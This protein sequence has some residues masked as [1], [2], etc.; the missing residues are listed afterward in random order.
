MVNWGP[1]QRLSLARIRILEPRGAIRTGIISSMSYYARFVED[2]NGQRF[3]FDTRIY[4]CSCKIHRENDGECVG[5]FVGL[6]P[7]SAEPL[8]KTYIGTW[9]E[10]KGEGDPTLALIRRC[11]I[12]AAGK[13]MPRHSFVQVWNLFYRCEPTSSKV[14]RLAGAFSELRRCGSERTI[15]PKLVWYAW[16]GKGLWT[17]KELQVRKNEFLEVDHDAAIYYGNTMGSKYRA[18]TAEAIS[19]NPGEK[20]FVGHPARKGKRA[21]PAV[22]ALIGQLLWG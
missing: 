18:D 2:Q 11:F 16:G 21:E 4:L 5:A 22:S 17:R 3:R 1:S 6:N 9:A 15:K 7:G 12:G 19:G 13:E 20:S 10:I 14:H 8:N